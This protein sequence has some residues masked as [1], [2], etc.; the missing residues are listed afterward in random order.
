MWSEVGTQIGTLQVRGASRDIPALRFSIGNLLNNLELKPQA[1]S[2]SSI[3]I[4][5]KFSDPLPQRFKLNSNLIHVEREWEQAVQQELTNICRQAS[6]PAR[7]V[8]LG[9]P[10]S[11]LF[12]DEAELLACLALSISSGQAWS[13]WWWQVVLKTIPAFLGRSAGITKVFCERARYIPAALDLLSN[14]GKAVPVLKA[15]SNSDAFTILNAMSHVHDLDHLI[16]NLGVQPLDNQLEQEYSRQ[17]TWPAQEMDEQKMSG[18][19]ILKTQP[20]DLNNG[21]ALW[22]RVISSVSQTKSLPKEQVALLGLGLTL[23]KSPSIAQRKDFQQAVINWWVRMGDSLQVTKGSPKREF[24]IRQ[25]SRDHMTETDGN[26]KEPEKNLKIH[27][28]DGKRHHE[29]RQPGT[30]QGKAKIRKI[31][32]A[33]DKQGRISQE[34]ALESLNSKYAR[35]PDEKVR[36]NPVKTVEQPL[37]LFPGTDFST[38]GIRTRL[39]GVLY[40]INLMGQLNLPYSFEPDWQVA[41]QL[42]AWGT[43]EV[44]ARA[45][46]A[47]ENV[48]LLSDSVWPALAELDNRDHDVPAGSFF[49]G[50]RQYNL[51]LAW[52]RLCPEAKKKKI[53]W[54]A[55]EKQFRIWSEF[56]FV[57]I[58]RP[59]DVVVTSEYVRTALRPYCDSIEDMKICRRAYA[60]AP[61]LSAGSTWFAGMSHALIHWLTLITPFV[62][63]QLTRVLKFSIKNKSDLIKSIFYYQGTLYVSKSHVD[64]VMTLND[65]S[66]PIRIAGFDRNPGWM[67]DFGRVI[68]FHFD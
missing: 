19:D 57:L 61:V 53:F 39:G 54:A 17:S 62:R 13:C 20:E 37:Q 55:R 7:G 32:S 68:S 50:A 8:I 9:E 45:L 58:D 14:W 33:S 34:P 21:V 22:E 67:K 10:D 56:S 42:G 23:Q 49:R 36:T 46:L 25:K 4:V 41:S 30:D 59:V 38:E 47:G 24:G 28:K 44:M 52:W 3:F 5:R 26:S 66:L 11:V 27:G 18:Q 16:S 29:S 35:S 60:D 12:A 40:L 6:R 43:L 2:P 1:F 48:E 31:R 63:F 64:L 15:I 51:P 65:I